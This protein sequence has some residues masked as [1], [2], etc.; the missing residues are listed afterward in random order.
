MAAVERD[1]NVCNSG[2]L[3]TGA[4]GSYLL[5]AAVAEGRDA[6][7]IRARCLTTGDPVML[8]VPAVRAPLYASARLGMPRVRD[9]GD[10]PEGTFMALDLADGTPL[11]A[12]ARREGWA[13]DRTWIEAFVDALCEAVASLHE[14]PAIAHGALH[15][16]NILL[17][18][19][20]HSVSVRL[21]DLGP[22]WIGDRLDE[23]FHAPEADAPTPRSD[24]FSLCVVLFALA[25]GSPRVRRP[26][27]DAA[28]W[29]AWTTDEDARIAALETQA[30]SLPAAVRR[31]MADGL[32]H[33]P[34]DRPEDA[35]ALRAALREAWAAP[36]GLFERV[37]G[38]FAD[39]RETPELRSPRE[40]VGAPPVQRAWAAEGT[41]AHGRWASLVLSGVEMRF[42]WV[43]AGTYLMGSS[44]REV[45]HRAEEGPPRA[46]TITRGLWLGETSV[47]QDQWTAVMGT[48]PSQFVSGRRPVDHVSYGDVEEFLACVKQR[49]GVH[50][51][52]LPT[53]AEW[54]YA[55]RA[56]TTTAT[57]AGDLD[58]LGDNNAPRLDA[59]AW[60]G[61]N[62]GVG[63]ELPNGYESGQW[64]E[65]QY[66]HT[67][68]GTRIV[69]TKAAN[70]WGLYDMLG[71][72]SE[73][74]NDWMGRYTVDAA[75]DPQGP[76]AGERKVMR[77][78]SWIASAVNVRAAMRY[79]Y[80]PDRR[81]SATGFR[82]AR[83][84]QVE[85]E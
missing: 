56:G 23:A 14:D 40:V 11:A 47:T 18:E 72:V 4:V 29:A 42:R 12:W 45:G 34:G 67:R 28:P 35:R 73:W 20:A 31:V 64:Q 38:L 81:D 52:R 32:S 54:E 60:Y 30:G 22:P 61:G 63:F 41:D 74:C 7:L 68:T 6:R 24:V 53:E 39:P 49:D 79:F 46:V 62:S 21:V 71:N 55:C 66:P 1:G 26:E 83:D 3:A 50:G 44:P 36:A 78:G 17:V 69:A 80:Y 75:R 19:H 25:T 58:V 70:P 84:M 59:I 27:G 5:G 8:I 33:D 16:D 9:Q 10:A 15:P 85:G 13:P 65:K 57:W 37:H 2:D 76:Y 51:L 82:L 77:G 48:N 43:R